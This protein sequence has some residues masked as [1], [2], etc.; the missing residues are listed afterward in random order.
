MALA[1]EWNHSK[2][3]MLESRRHVSSLLAKT[4]E[5]ADTRPTFPASLPSAE[6][7]SGI[8]SAPIGICP[9]LSSSLRDLC[10]WGFTRWALSLNDM[11]E[12]LQRL[13]PKSD[14]RW[15]GDVRA[16]EQGKYDEA[17]AE[18][19]RLLRRVAAAR[20]AATRPFQPRWFQ[21]HPEVN[22]QP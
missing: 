22:P 8:C 14:M 4:A 1:L 7:A 21:L 6:G 20:E 5:F 10:R 17:E 13:L 9:D 18:R 2:L 3:H 16:L 19:R 12:G 15:R 11:P